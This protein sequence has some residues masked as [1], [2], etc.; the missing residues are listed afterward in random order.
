MKKEIILSGGVVKE[1][2]FEEVLVEFEAMIHQKANETLSKIIYNKPEKEDLVQELKLQTWEAF[3]RYD[4]SNQ[5][6]TY[7]FYRLKLGVNNTCNGMLAQKRQ[8]NGL[9][10]LNKEL[11]SD[12]EGSIE[13]LLG[14]EDEDLVSVEFREFLKYLSEMLS[15]DEKKI[16]MFFIDKKDRTVAD[17]AREWGVS[18]VA[19]NNRVRKF[20]EKLGQLLLSTNYVE[21]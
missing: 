8:N 18:R 19:A 5:F 3:Q 13:S 21:I 20:R 10:S 9:I 14:E 7:L 1:M 4:G 16:L 11:D 17:L 12:G 15:D 6:S 2:T